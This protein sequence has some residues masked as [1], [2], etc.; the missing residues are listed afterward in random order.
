MSPHVSNS[1]EVALKGGAHNTYD[2]I[3]IK[4]MK[5]KSTCP[6]SQ[7]S[8]GLN[9]VGRRRQ[10]DFE[11]TDKGLPPTL[12]EPGQIQ[13]HL[14]RFSDLIFSAEFHRGRLVD[15]NQGS[16]SPLVWQS[17]ANPCSLWTESIRGESSAFY[18]KVQ[19]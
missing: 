14:E 8:E 13:F 16:G 6:D 7:E 12:A 17:Y 10:V 4:A 3:Q 9:S 11:S 18:L 5:F 19:K 1:P 15:V 2:A